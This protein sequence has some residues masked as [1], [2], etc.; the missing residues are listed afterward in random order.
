MGLFEDFVSNAQDAINNVGSMFTMGAEKISQGDVLGGLGSMG[1]GT[2]SGVA[3][4]VTGGGANAIGNV[5]KDAVSDNFVFEEK[6]LDNGDTVM[7]VNYDSGANANL[8]DKILGAAMNSTVSKW[9]NSVIESD[10]Y[11]ESGDVA[12]ANKSSTP[13]FFDGFLTP[14]TIIA[15]G[16]LSVAANSA[17]AAAQAGTA[18]AE[19]VKHAESMAKAAKVA[20]YAKKGSKYTNKALGGIDSIIDF[21]NG[22]IDLPGF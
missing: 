20:N 17:N 7:S 13:L 5:V 1:L 12:S 3:N 15:S 16:A 8:M 22:N 19:A 18:T 10:K 6:T 14:A 11:L 4:F 9:A 21:F 2:L